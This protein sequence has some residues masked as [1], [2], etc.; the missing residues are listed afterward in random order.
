MGKQTSASRAL[1][2][3]LFTWKLSLKGIRFLL[4]YL[5]SD[6]VPFFKNEKKGQPPLWLGKSAKAAS[7]ASNRFLRAS[8]RCS[9]RGL[10]R[11]LLRGHCAPRL[12]HL[13]SAG[14]QLGPRAVGLIGFVFNSGRIERVPPACGFSFGPS[15]TDPNPTAFKAPA[16]YSLLEPGS[17]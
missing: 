16:L 9:F 4:P 6:T 14:S 8:R 13:H 5:G 3:G 12:G 10:P 7:Q 15:I 1:S 2:A 11:G 17:S